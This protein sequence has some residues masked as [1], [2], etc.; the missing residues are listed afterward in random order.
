MGDR[1]IRG[2]SNALDGETDRPRI[3]E[4]DIHVEVRVVLV[5]D[6][7]GPLWASE[8]VDHGRRSTVLEL[9]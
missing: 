6:H 9:Q 1:A 3:A 2:Q 8:P 4:P 7:V 5:A